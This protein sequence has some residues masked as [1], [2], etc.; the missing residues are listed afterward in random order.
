MLVPKFLTKSNRNFKQL[1]GL[2]CKTWLLSYF[3][4]HD[5]LGYF[6][7]HAFLGYFEKH[8][9]LGYFEKHDIL[10][11]FEK[12]D[13]LFRDCCGYIWATFLE[14]GLLFI[15]PSGHTEDGVQ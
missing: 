15:L 11:Y 1:F 13:F 5:F 2:F 4:K 3:V 12:H 9:F 10:G 14:I 7:K 8:G 6:E